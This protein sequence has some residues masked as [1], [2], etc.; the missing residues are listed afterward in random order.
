[1]PSQL[2]LPKEKR[3]L[4]T[5][6][7][8]FKE[9]QKPITLFHRQLLQALRESNDLSPM[10]HSIRERIKDPGH[11]YGKLKRKL[12]EAKEAG[13]QFGITQQNLFT[14][15][16]DLAGIRI[17]H[18][19]SRQI[20]QIN[21]ALLKIFREQRYKLIEKPFARTWD[22]ESRQFLKEC[23][24]R[25]EK[26]PSLYTSVHYIVESASRTKIRCEIQV[27][28]LMEEVWGEVAHLINY[29]DQTTNVAIREQIKVLARITSSATRL[30]DSIF[31]TFD[32]F[33]KRGGDS[34]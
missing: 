23:G 25:T 27:R 9:N 6:V 19:R 8:Y 2:L 16:N 15:I 4:N 34:K 12:C 11:L 17:L 28:T 20:A 14:Q 31:L 29:P 22:D 5:L 3:N 32:D 10:V 30:V 13:H 33:K 18:L 7:Q 21:P 1:M 26:S 24:I